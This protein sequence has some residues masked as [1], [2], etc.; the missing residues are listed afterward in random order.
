MNWQRIAFSS[1][2]KIQA[3]DAF[4]VLCWTFSWMIMIAFAIE[5]T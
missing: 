5:I 3:I 4:C 1:F 2:W